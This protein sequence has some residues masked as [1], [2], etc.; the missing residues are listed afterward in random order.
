MSLFSVSQK[1]TDLIV[2]R[3]LISRLISFCGAGRAGKLV[4]E[5]SQLI[6]ICAAVGLLY[7]KIELGN[8]CGS[9]FFHRFVSGSRIAKH[10]KKEGSNLRKKETSVPA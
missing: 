9:L 8:L 5:F 7:L 3:C 10:D 6:K 1:G 2:C 4:S